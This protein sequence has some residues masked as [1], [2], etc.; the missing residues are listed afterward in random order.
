M[1]RKILNKI[2]GT[3]NEIMEKIEEQEDKEEEDKR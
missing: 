2:R 1:E 3:N